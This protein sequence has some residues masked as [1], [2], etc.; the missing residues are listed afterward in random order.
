MCRCEVLIW[1]DTGENQLVWL[2]DHIVISQ[3]MCK[4]SLFWIRQS[5]FS[6]KCGIKFYHDCFVTLFLNEQLYFDSETRNSA[7]VNLAQNHS[8]NKPV[9]GNEGEV[10]YSRKQQELLWL[11]KQKNILKKCLDRLCK[12][13][14]WT[15]LA[16]IE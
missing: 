14:N 11:D 7:G 10:S 16:T 9:L 13:S 4:I 8:R 15:L 1:K 3:S 12:V 5:G 2:M 6:Y